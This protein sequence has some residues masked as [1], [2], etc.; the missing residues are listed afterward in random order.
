[1]FGMFR[2]KRGNL[3]P[4]RHSAAPPLSADLKAQHDREFVE[5]LQK[6]LD[7]QTRSAGPGKIEPSF[8]APSP[9]EPASRS[10]R[11]PQTE[12]KAANGT[13][14]KPA[15][16]VAPA[17]ARRDERPQPILSLYDFDALPRLHGT[18]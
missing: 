8:K 3:G 11:T 2:K 12:V 13:A 16:S 15:A 18:K 6:G 10:G 9:S 5:R 14:P 1:M 4:E 17:P 7:A